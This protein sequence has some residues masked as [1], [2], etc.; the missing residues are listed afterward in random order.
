MKNRFLLLVFFL[1]VPGTF[2]TGQ[3]VTIDFEEYA[4]GIVLSNQLSLS[5][6][7]ISFPKGLQ[8]VDCQFSKW[9]DA[10]SGGA[11]SG[12]KL[13]IG[14]AYDEFVRNAINIVFEERQDSVTLYLK[15]GN[16]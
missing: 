4:S 11:H 6:L 10:G 13:G 7:G 1:L 12:N 16:Y 15:P 3:R 8:V 5:S 14:S 9:C 2:L